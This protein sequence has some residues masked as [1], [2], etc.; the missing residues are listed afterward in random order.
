M[1]NNVRIEFETLEGLNK[2][3][4]LNQPDLNIED[5]RLGASPLAVL[6]G[7]TA[8]RFVNHWKVWHAG[9][10]WQFNVER[11]SKLKASIWGRIFDVDAGV[12]WP[13]PSSPNVHAYLRVGIDPS[14][15]L[16]P[17]SS[18]V[19]WNE[20]RVYDAYEKI[21][22]ET[23][24]L[25]TQITVFVGFENGRNGMWELAKMYG[26]LDALEL[27]IEAPGDEPPTE[28]PPASTGPGV[29]IDG[30]EDLG[31]HI[32]LLLRVPKTQP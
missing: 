8:L 3:A 16:S 27:A 1:T 9:V 7:P 10:Y 15:G 30:A 11:F 12:P 19:I 28:P 5:T 4:I 20:E 32:R 14:G 17:T 21:A 29:T 26:F 6:S 13:G 23:I 22:V 2:W 18:G 31:S 24:A 25:G